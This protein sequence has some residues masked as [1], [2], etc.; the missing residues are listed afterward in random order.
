MGRCQLSDSEVYD[1]PPESLRPLL[2]DDGFGYLLALHRQI[3]GLPG[4][5]GT[6]DETNVQ[7]PEGVAGG[8]SRHED[9]E[10]VT[11]FQH[12]GA[13]A[14]A[15]LDQAAAVGDA[16]A[17]ETTTIHVDAV[18]PIDIPGESTLD[19]FQLATVELKADL[20]ALVGFVNGIVAG[21]NALAGGH[22]LLLASLRT[23]GLLAGTG[24]DAGGGTGGGGG[25]DGTGTGGS[26][27]AGGPPSPSADVAVIANP[28]SAGGGT[29]LETAEA[30][31]V[32]TTDVLQRREVELT[33]AGAP[34]LAAQAMIPG[35]AL[36]LALVAEV[37][38]AIQGTTSW[39][40]GL[41]F[42]DDAWGNA[43]GVTPG[44]ATSLAD[45]NFRSPFYVQ[46]ALDV[47]LRANGGTFAGGKVRLTL[48]YWTTP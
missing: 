3:F 13:G 19:L 41:S 8:A 22:N 37:T 48:W 42:D 4:E 34:E 31:G 40:L 36:V 26:G 27:A 2:G 5:T 47:R 39:R 33:T 18:V 29:V 1:Q 6:L 17:L 11:P 43:I 35:N 44:A 45:F 32:I 16:G 30:S 7:F 21:V 15:G 46:S 23:A 14:H 9:L 25:D 20:N 38:Q 24:G 12:H 28:S 10:D